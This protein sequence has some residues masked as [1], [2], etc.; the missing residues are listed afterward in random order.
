MQFD[1]ET[2]ETTDDLDRLEA[3]LARRRNVITSKY[4]ENNADGDPAKII[5][6]LTSM[7]DLFLLQM[8][9]Y[10]FR[11]NFEGSGATYD[12]QFQSRLGWRSDLATSMNAMHFSDGIAVNMH[13]DPGWEYRY[14]FSRVEEV[15]NG[16]LDYFKKDESIGVEHPYCNNPRAFRVYPLNC[17]GPP[18]GYLSMKRAPQQPTM[19]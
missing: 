10:D 11:R 5:P 13:K 18:K 19:I 16:L 1:V 17:E 14:P 7:M 12:S 3:A 15:F 8:K 2:I 9:S 6:L 4:R